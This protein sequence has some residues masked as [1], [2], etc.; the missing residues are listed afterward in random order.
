MPRDEASRRPW[1]TPDSSVFPGFSCGF[2]RI[3]TV[4]VEALDVRC[5]PEIRRVRERRRGAVTWEFLPM[6]KPE[7]NSAESERLRQLFLGR[8]ARL[9]DTGPATTN[10]AIQDHGLIAWA[11]ISTYPACVTAGCQDGSLEVIRRHRSE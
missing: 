9:V 11:L 5:T 1:S 2:N 3:S 7:R 10:T 8:L 6:R 4:W